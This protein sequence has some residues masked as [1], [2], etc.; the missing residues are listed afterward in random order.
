MIKYHVSCQQHLQT[1]KIFNPINPVCHTSYI[2]WGYKWT[3]WFLLSR[4]DYSG[5]ISTKTITMKWEIYYNEVLPGY[6]LN[7]MA[8]NDTNKTSEVLLF[9]LC[10]HLILFGK[11][12]MAVMIMIKVPNDKVANSSCALKFRSFYFGPRLK[13]KLKNFFGYANGISLPV[14]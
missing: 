14:F 12:F 10:P 11:F 8:K 6:S 13:L 1:V 5:E 3:D 4:V 9:Y 2:H 7:F